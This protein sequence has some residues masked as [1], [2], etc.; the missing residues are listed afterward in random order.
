MV[1]ESSRIALSARLEGLTRGVS[2]YFNKI[3]D[4][5]S[6]SSTPRDTKP[7]IIKPVMSVNFILAIGK[8]SHFVRSLLVL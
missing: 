2:R 3:T 5:N 8:S 6:V 1:I 4:E 7:V